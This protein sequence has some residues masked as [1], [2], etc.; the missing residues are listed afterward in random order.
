MREDRT[1]RAEEMAEKLAVKL[2]VPMVM[3]IFPALILILVGPA[4]LTIMRI[5]AMP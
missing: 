5:F 1:Y 2:I 3:F 4:G